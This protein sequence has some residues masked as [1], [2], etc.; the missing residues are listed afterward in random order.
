M[1]LHTFNQRVNPP[2][3][4][5]P[6][7]PTRIIRVTDHISKVRRLAAHFTLRHRKSLLYLEIGADSPVNPTSKCTRPAE[8]LKDP[9]AAQRR[10]PITGL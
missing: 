9:A 3:I 6:A 10:I 4:R 2:K 7:A 1:L 8:S 5:I